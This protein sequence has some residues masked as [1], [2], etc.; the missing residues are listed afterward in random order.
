MKKPK[1]H[2]AYT[3]DTGLIIQQ[4][5][6]FGL[7]NLY[8]K[9]LRKKSKY[10]LVI[11]FV[12]DGTIEIYQYKKLIGDLEKVICDRNKKNQ[13]FFFKNFDKF[14]SDLNYFQGL[15][16]KGLIDSPDNFKK[17]IRRLNVWV[18]NYILYYHTATNNHSPKKM[19]KIVRY[20]R[21]TD[22]YW[23]KA[24]NYL[25]QSLIHLYPAINGLEDVILQNEVGLIPTIETLKERKGGFV[26]IG[27]KSFIGLITKLPYFFGPKVK[28][29][30]TIKGQTAF[31]GIARGKVFILKSVSNS[32]KIKKG[33]I[34][35]SP[36]TT[37]D[38]L[39]AMQ[40][41]AAIVTDEGGITCHAA[42]VAREMKKPCIIGTKVATKVL[43]NGDIVE[44][45]AEKG[46]V[47]ILKKAGEK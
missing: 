32:H 25:R 16:K 33:N 27:R 6:A 13:D 23:S 20:F 22:D 47:K 38:M 1:Y 17:V 3:R 45:D 15:W 10:P 24:A 40:K 29:T 4:S 37:P 36:M 34:L 14:K 9:L 12:V 2:L 31:K 19:L 44:V 41:A 39:S 28:R 5:W 30:N 46:V 18:E 42:I 7:E 21:Q 43:K 26:V 35:V 11:D 8:K